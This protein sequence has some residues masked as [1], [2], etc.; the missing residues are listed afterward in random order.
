MKRAPVIAGALLLALIL[1]GCSIVTPDKRPDDQKLRD[2]INLLLR[3]F[4]DHHAQL[5]N[6][7]LALV[8]QQIEHPLPKGYATEAG[9]TLEWNKYV[10]GELNK[11]V[12]P[13]SI[14]GQLP[15]KFALDIDN[16]SGGKIV[17]Q[18]TEI[19]VRRAQQGKDYYLAGIVHI[20][21]SQSDPNWIIFTSVPYLPFTDTA[22]GFAHRADGKWSVNDFGT[23]TV[24]C[25]RVP[26]SIITE[27][28]MSCPP[29]RN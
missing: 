21:A 9:W 15:N 2:G 6:W 13:W 5:M 24:G 17:P 7:N 14:I 29:G 27:F 23:A 12:I 1:S 4:S 8:K 16:Y 18:S 25:G 3:D 10:Q 11:V 20:R 19:E 28:G 26:I 22:Y